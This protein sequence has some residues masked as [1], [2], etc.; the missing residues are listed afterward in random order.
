MPQ[1]CAVSQ[2]GLCPGTLRLMAS[3]WFDGNELSALAGAGNHGLEL[4][5]YTVP[6]F[7]P[8]PAK[9]LL[10]VHFGGLQRT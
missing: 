3:P 9:C 7:N 8:P 2:K 6:G 1:G 10:S 4:R 5:R